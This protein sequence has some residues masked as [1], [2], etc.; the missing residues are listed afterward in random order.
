MESGGCCGGSKKPTKPNINQASKAS[1]MR[2]G[3]NPFNEN[4]LKEKNV[5]QVLEAKVVLL[6][7]SGV[8]KSSI[9]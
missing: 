7:D 1:Q 3:N 5:S 4:R 2:V 9:A 6:G 8:G